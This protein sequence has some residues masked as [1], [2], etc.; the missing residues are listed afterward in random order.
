M[1]TKTEVLA[2]FISEPFSAAELEQE[3]GFRRNGISILMLHMLANGHLKSGPNRRL[4]LQDPGRALEVADIL[5]RADSEGRL[6][7]GDWPENAPYEVPKTRGG[8]RS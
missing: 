1:P 7:S 6:S 2:V 8:S 3:F 5:L 4:T